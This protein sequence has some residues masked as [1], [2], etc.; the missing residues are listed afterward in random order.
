[1]LKAASP[2]LP[3][4]GPRARDTEFILD[5]LV[6]LTRPQALARSRRLGYPD[7]PRYGPKYQL[8]TCRHW[9]EETRLCG[10]YEDRPDMCRDYPYSGRDC[11]RGCSY[12]LSEEDERVIKARGNSTWEWD[13][14][15]NGWRPKSNTDFLWDAEHG[16]LRAV[17]GKVD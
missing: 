9:N 3:Q 10:A 8:F 17:P 2:F 5:M 11:E 13:A 6:P 12:K 1:M 4:K 14:E 15:A 16:V 7:P